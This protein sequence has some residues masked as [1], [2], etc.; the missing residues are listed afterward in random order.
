MMAQTAPNTGAGDDVGE[1]PR[2]VAVLAHPDDET[3]IIGGTLALYAERGCDV[4]VIY[5]PFG[6]GENGMPTPE[7][8]AELEAA[9]GFSESLA[10]VSCLWGWTA[11][12]RLTLKHSLTT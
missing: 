10:G 7:R 1:R 4:R 9:A 6:A 12:E 5:G 8:L 2:I 11:R 3:F